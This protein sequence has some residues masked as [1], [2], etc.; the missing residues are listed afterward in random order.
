MKPLGRIDSKRF[1][2]FLLAVGCRFIS[3]EASHRKFRKEGILRPIIVP[4]TND[5]PDFIILNN[6]RTL[7]VTRGDFV[8]I[9]K[10]L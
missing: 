1:E 6:L 8:R 4:F 9:A 10:K 2:R 7:G 3:Q 5:L